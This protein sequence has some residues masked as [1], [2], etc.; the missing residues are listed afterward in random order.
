MQITVSNK[1]PTPSMLAIITSHGGEEVTWYV[2]TKSIPDKYDVFEEINSFWSTCDE[3]KQ[4]AIFDSYCDIFKT[5]NECRDVTSMIFSLRPLVAKLFDF[6]PQDQIRYWVEMRGRLQIPTGIKKVFDPDKMIGTREKTYIVEDYQKLVP[7]AISFRI[8]IPIWGEF[9]NR[10]KNDVNTNFISQQAF[11]L[12]ATSNVMHC[13]AMK[14]LDLF[15]RHVRVKNRPVESAVFAGISSENLPNWVIAN[16]V[17]KRL[18][19]GDVRGIEP[20]S[21]LVTFM[22]NFMEQKLKD[23]EDQGRVTVKHDTS[24]GGV[25][26]ENNHSRLEGFKIKQDIPAGDIVLLSH[27]IRRAIDMAYQDKPLT[28][29]CLIRRLNPNPDFVNYVIKSHQSVEA[30]SEEKL[31]HAQVTLAAWVLNKY[32]SIRAMGYLTKQDVLAVIALA[33][34]YLWYNGHRDLA[35]VVSAIAK[36]G[37]MLDDRVIGDSKSNMTDVQ[38][39][40]FARIFP[41]ERRLKSRKTAKS[42][43]PQVMSINNM[44][45]IFSANA[46]QL[47][48]PEDWVSQLRGNSRYR[49]YDIPSDIR[50]KL[51]DLVIELDDRYLDENVLPIATQ[52]DI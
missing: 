19:S 9:M 22:Y 5:M 32:V 7:M 4:K 16:V 48:L 45:D 21:T 17:V 3:A 18:S 10:N 46:W 40:K 12:V 23:L 34:A 11:E 50:Q 49:R 30:L 43:S 52:H 1:T 42:V 47:T 20:E 15:A 35:A 6:H 37:G 24:S 13:D 28:P 38:A 44:V 26:D 29:R 8:M 27:Y 51:A 31:N 39:E 14:R 25:N 33:Q 36:R 41:F 2:P